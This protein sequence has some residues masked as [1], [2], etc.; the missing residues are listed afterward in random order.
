ML[1]FESNFLFCCFFIADMDSPK[2]QIM[3]V[4]PSKKLC[5]FMKKYIV[6]RFFFKA[7]LHK[8]VFSTA[9]V[10]V[11]KFLFF[12]S[13]NDLFGG[14]VKNR[15]ALLIG[16]NFGVIRAADDCVSMHFILEAFH[17]F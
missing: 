11:L 15:W 12:R 8:G 14:I 2:N 7:F 6:S 1:N 5:R 10:H 17:T 3:N 4:H 16:Q 9:K 13:S